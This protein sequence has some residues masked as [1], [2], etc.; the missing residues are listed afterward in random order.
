MAAVQLVVAPLGQALPESY[1][2]CR[3]ATLR[4]PIG[5]P[6]G[7]E[8]LD[9][10]AEAIHAYFETA[11][12]T[13]VAV[14]RIRM[15]PAESDGSQADHAGANAS[16][17]P[18][19]TPLTASVGENSGALRPAVQVRQMGTMASHRRQGLAGQL[20]Q[21][22]EHAAARQW[23]ARS[24]WCY[25]RIAAVSMYAGQGWASYGG[26]Y[27]IKGVGPHFS[28]TKVLAQPEQI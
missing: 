9:D 10:D 19:F 2:E 5:M 8:R 7:A 22:L 11:D 25:A 20:V 13:V 28:M 15:I 27:D 16:K 17:C 1:Y 23:G 24:A 21:A 6:P 18:A 4:Q 3:Y 12:G 14:G 26:E